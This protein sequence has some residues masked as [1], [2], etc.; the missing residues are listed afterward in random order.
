MPRCRVP[1]FWMAR[2]SALIIVAIVG[3]TICY[4]GDVNRVLSLSIFSILV[5]RM[6]GANLCWIKHELHRIISS[7]LSPIIYADHIEGSGVAVF[8]KCCD[9]DSRAP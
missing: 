7:S 8:E 9:L 3:S 5:A 2:L 6:C 4:S 1:W